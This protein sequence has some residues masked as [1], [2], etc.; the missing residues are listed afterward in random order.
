LKLDVRRSGRRFD[1]DARL[2]LPADLRTVWGT[3]TDYDALPAFMPGIRA[4]RVLERRALAD[5]NERL[6]VE[7]QGEFRLLRFAQAMTV[8]LN[9]EHQRLHTAS[10]QA[11]SV[12]LGIFGRHAVDVFEGRYELTALAA[13]HGMPR[14]RLRY[15]A[16]IG[17]RLP[18]PPAVGSL[19]VRQNLGAQLEAIAREVLRRRGRVA[20]ESAAS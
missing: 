4:C 12:E 6:R 5:G 3:I 20:T 10:A 8:M 11:L 17:L 2:E 16:V 13:H 15:S 19:A 18:P 14:T 9:I 1:A 7:Q